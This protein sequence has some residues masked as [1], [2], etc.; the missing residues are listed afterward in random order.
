MFTTN[1]P[2]FTKRVLFIG[3][4]DMAYVCLDGLLQA[5]VNIVGVKDLKKLM[6]HMIVSNALLCPEI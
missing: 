3:I 1:Q 4:P 2:Q 6:V 5:G